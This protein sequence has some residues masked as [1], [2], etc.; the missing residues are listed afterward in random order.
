MQEMCYEVVF[1]V[2]YQRLKPL[3]CHTDIIPH[4]LIM[5]SRICAIIR[6]HI[7]I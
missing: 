5:S 7:L 3:A 6:L 2:N 1:D 4:L